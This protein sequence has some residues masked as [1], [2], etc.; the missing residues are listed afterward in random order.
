MKKISKKIKLLLKSMNDVET[1]QQLYHIC[2]FKLIIE[3]IK[4]LQ[5]QELS[6]DEQ[7]NIYDNVEIYYTL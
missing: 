7:I 3:S 4:K 5:S 1:K 2:D 6:W